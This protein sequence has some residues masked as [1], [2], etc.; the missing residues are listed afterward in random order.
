MKYTGMDSKTVS[1]AI[2][3]IK[4]SSVLDRKKVREF[5]AY[6]NR[7]HYINMNAHKKD[8]NNYFYE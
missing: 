8:L 6:L 7:L 4:Y 3:R 1:S 2:S 5:V